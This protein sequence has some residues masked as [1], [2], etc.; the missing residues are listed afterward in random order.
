MSNNFSITN[1]AVNS[2]FE[3]WL[4]ENHEIEDDLELEFLVRGR[5]GK[6]VFCISVVSARKYAIIEKTWAK[7]SSFIYSIALTSDLRKSLLPD[8]TDIKM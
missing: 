7:Y 6:G 4:V 2:L 8:I 5:N 1:E 3:R